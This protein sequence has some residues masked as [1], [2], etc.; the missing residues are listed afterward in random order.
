MKGMSMQ[1][2]KRKLKPLGQ[3][4]STLSDIHEKDNLLRTIIKLDI[5]EKDKHADDENGKFK[6]LRQTNSIL[7][8]K[9]DFPMLDKDPSCG[10]F[11]D[12]KSGQ[13]MEEDGSISAKRFPKSASRVATFTFSLLMLSLKFSKPLLLPQG[14]HSLWLAIAGMFSFILLVSAASVMLFVGA[15]FTQI[16][17]T[18]MLSAFLGLL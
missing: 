12:D 3:M 6:P 18:V 4:N 8:S 17:I 5:H 10:T 1:M 16:Q 2:M 15:R 9:Q 7:S 13:H 11:H 14:P